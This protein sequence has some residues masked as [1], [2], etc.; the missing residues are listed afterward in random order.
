MG[1]RNRLG[2]DIFCVIGVI[3]IKEIMEEYGGVILACFMG[4]LFIGI[5]TELIDINGGVS[6]LARIFAQGIGSVC[7]R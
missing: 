2:T 3:V 6:H 7:S 1:R 5:F 4:L